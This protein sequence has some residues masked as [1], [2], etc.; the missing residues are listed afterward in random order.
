MVEFVCDVV[1][2]FLL[3]SIEDKDERE[4]KL[5][6]TFSLISS[7]LRETFRVYYVHVDDI[8]SILCICIYYI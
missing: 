5:C 2:S 1:L 6:F 4:E 3:S 8:R 7:W